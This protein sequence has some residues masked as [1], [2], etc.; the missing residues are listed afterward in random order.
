M[1]QTKKK[2]RWGGEGEEW[3]GG[4]RKRQGGVEGREEVKGGGRAEKETEKERVKFLE[5]C[6]GNKIK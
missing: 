4:K 2:G 1:S 6:F 3:K 5:V